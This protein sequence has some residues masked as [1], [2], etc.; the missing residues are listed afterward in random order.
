M[1]GRDAEYSHCLERAHHGYLDADE[2]PALCA[3]GSGSVTTSLSGETPGQGVVA[4]SQRCWWRRR[5]ARLRRAWLLANPRL[6]GANGSGDYETGYDTTAQAV[7]IGQ[8]F[9]DADLVWLGRDEQGRA[10]V[11]QGRVAEGFRLVD[12]ALGCR[13][14]GELSPMVTGIVY[15][16]TI[17]FGA[18]AYEVRHA[19]QMDRRPNEMVRP[20]AGD[21]GSQ[22]ALP[23]PSG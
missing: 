5:R 3:A 13:R 20:P 12:E 23:C 7:V 19:T 1:L 6:V 4:R 10:L 14:R 16:N 17:A 21:G 22:R 8:R 15:C 11:G 9:A 2:S 18:K